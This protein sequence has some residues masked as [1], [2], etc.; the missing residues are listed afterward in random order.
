MMRNG[1]AASVVNRAAFEAIAKTHERFLANPRHGK[2]MLL[3]NSVVDGIQTTAV[4]LRGACFISVTFRDCSFWR[5]NLAEAD[6]E[7]SNL[8][9]TS[10]E[11]SNLRKARLRGV[12][13]HGDRKSTRLNSSH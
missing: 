1:S 3:A 10:F 7:L 13:L 8:E 2:R 4:D 12:R 5:T 6:F 9:G 11:G